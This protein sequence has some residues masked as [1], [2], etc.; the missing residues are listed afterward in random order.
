MKNCTKCGIEK[1]LTEFVKDKYSKD[2]YTTSCKLCRKQAGINYRFNNPEEYNK[3]LI[4]SRKKMYLIHREKIKAKT[5]EYY[6]NNKEKCLEYDKKY[7][8]KNPEKIKIKQE[9]YRLKNNERR[10]EKY[11]DNPEVFKQKVKEYRIKNPDKIKDTAYRSSQKYKDKAREWKREWENARI[12]NDSIYSLK[13]KLRCR[14]TAAIKNGGYTK[15]SSCGVL[16]GEEYHIIKAYIERKFKKGMT[17]DNHGLWHIDHKIPLASAKTEEEL[18]KLCHYTNL[19][20]LWKVDNLKKG[21]QIIPIQT[22][23]TL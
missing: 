23:M 13:R 21:S 11:S 5:R 22:I 15:K 17:W 18:L 10:R 8:A 6:R 19:Q 4:K 1:E 9:R 2:G 20:P 14:I 3:S 7:H 12:K 16:L